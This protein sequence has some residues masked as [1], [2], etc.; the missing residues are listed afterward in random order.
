[1]ISRM[2]KMTTK[3]SRLSLTAVKGVKME[4]NGE[5]EKKNEN[6]LVD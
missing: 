2:G 5:T 6:T 1:M 3:N 4:I